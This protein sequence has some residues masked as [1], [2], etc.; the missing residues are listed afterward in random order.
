[1]IGK[2]KALDANE[3]DLPMSKCSLDKPTQNLIK[4]IFDQ[5]MFRSAMQNMEIGMYNASLFHLLIFSHLLS[6]FTL[7]SSTP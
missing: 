4:L 7:F 5:D 1:M 2:L 6:L 3:V